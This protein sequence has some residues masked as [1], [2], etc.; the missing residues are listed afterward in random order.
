[1]RI[2]DLRREK[3][4]FGLRLAATIHWEESARPP[5]DAWW[6]VDG[7]L[8]ESARPESN[9]FLAAAFVP[10]L[11]HGERRIAVEGSVCPL[12]GTGLRGIGGLLRSWYPAPAPIP[13]IEPSEGWIAP[14]PRSDGAVAGYLTG[15]VDS[16]HLFHSNRED[17]PADHPLRISHALW[18]R[19]LDFPGEE[20][21]SEAKAAYARLDGPISEIAEEAGVP[22]ARITTNLRRIEPDLSFYAH[23]HLGGALLSGAHLIA[24]RFSTVALG[25]SWPAEHL[26]PW[27]THPLLDVQYGSAAVSIRHEALGFTRIEKLG[28]LRPQT[29]SLERLVTCGDAPGIAS[30]NCGRCAKCV[31]TLVEMEASGTIAH[32]RSF[33]PGTVTAATIEG[34]ELDNGTEYFWG[35]LVAPLRAL[36][37]ENVASAI[38]RKIRA[39][40]RRRRRVEGRDWAAGIRRFDRRFLGGRLKQIHRGFRA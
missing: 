21:S 17:F 25:S 36:G 39:T 4:S 12:L 20:E 8:G 28:R 10:A 29:R 7:E 30:I 37:R 27:G 16:L 6:D 2:T 38:E 3:G 18:I 23:W 31:R 5:L 33:P 34:L 32:A 19:G 15:G 40:V 1:M 24:S 9:A 14:T 35:L 22:L 13:P 26:V 11:R